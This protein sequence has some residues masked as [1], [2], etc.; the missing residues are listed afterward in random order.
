MIHPLFPSPFA[1]G[2]VSLGAVLTALPATAQD[3][4]SNGVTISDST[5][6]SAALY[7]QDDSVLQDQACIGFSC[8]R[9]ETFI[10]LY[11]LKLNWSRPGIEFTDASSGPGSGS[12]N[13]FPTD[14]WRI[15]INDN[16]TIANGGQ[17]FFRLQNVS[18]GTR[19]LTVAGAAPTNALYIAEDGDIGLGTSLPQADLHITD[20]DGDP[21]I[22]FDDTG[23]SPYAWYLSGNSSGF[24]VYDPQTFDIPFEINAGAPENA[25]RILDNGNIGMSAGSTPQAPLHIARSDN[26]ARLLVEDTG[27]SGAQEMLKLSNT[28]GSY[29]TFE[30]A[31]AGTTWFFTHE[32]A[33]PNR[34]IIADAVA[35]G[36]EFTL[37]AG[38]DI[39]IP[40]NFISGNTTLNV[41][42]YV[43]ADDYALRPLSEV[44]AFIADNRHLPDV[45][46]AAQIAATGLDMTDMQMRLLQKVEELTL[47]TLE[48]ETRLARVDA[49]EAEN[50]ALH[51]RL[52]RIEAALAL[53]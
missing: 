39:T 40:G 38:G 20:P 42:D 23:F 34:F 26:T 53:E 22:R 24:Y 11:T 6:G 44:A 21:G 13:P 5:T 46:S 7:V 52:A 28:G 27:S 12:P 36:P 32:D 43:F 14:D 47:Y 48:Q 45:P 29:F 41:P 9:E 37:T 30:N 17:N 25:L 10:N 19:P 18:A 1:F 3:V 31:A 2:L 33:S 16:T 51:A 49:L 35:D 4:F 50:A 15:E 8:I